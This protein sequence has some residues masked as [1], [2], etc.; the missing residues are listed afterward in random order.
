MDVLLHMCKKWQIAISV[1]LYRWQANKE[2]II[3]LSAL[4][5]LIFIFPELRRANEEKKLHVMIQ[6][7]HLVNYGIYL[8]KLCLV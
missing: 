6:R 1:P 4:I 2:Q 5:S 3:N 7:V 8:F